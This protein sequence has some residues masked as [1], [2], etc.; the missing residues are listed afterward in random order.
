MGLNT[1]HGC[2]DGPYSTFNRFR[3]SLGHQIG[4]NLSDYKGY[5]NDNGKNL[6]DI[7][8]ELMPL[9]NHSDC[10]G[11]L[12]VEESRSIV[13]GLDKVLKNFNE[14]IEADYNFKEKI[15]TFR[16]GCLLAIKNNE[17]VEFF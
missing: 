6:Y 1:T 9:F 5:G 4:I 17:I 12:S 10:D 2:Y 15:K 8:H 7:E 13:K 3:Y 14:K 11:E 16:E